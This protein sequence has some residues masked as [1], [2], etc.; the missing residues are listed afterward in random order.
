MIE[1]KIFVPTVD[2]GPIQ[3]RLTAAVD[4]SIRNHSAT[5]LV[6]RAGAGKTFLAANIAAGIKRTAWYTLDAGDADWTVFQRYFRAVVLG[7]KERRMAD[8]AATEGDRTPFELIADVSSAL[9]H[10]KSKWPRLIVLDGVH[11]LYDSAWFKDLLEQV[12][13]SLPAPSH[14]LMTSRS[15]P[16]TSLWRLRSKQFLNVI[17]EKLLEITQAESEDLFSKNGLGRGDGKR[18]Y[19]ESYGR[20]GKLMRILESKRAAPR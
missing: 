12:I 15:K 8:A 10:R 7:K 11:H 5:M 9:D 19:L 18:A 14:L 17:D 1:S 3:K 13:S 20:A 4:R 16:P 2:K 6:G